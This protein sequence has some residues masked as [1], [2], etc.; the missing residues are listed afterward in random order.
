MPKKR[1]NEEKENSGSF[2][3]FMIVLIFI[4]IWLSVFALLIKFDAG[5]LGTTLRPYLKDI[6]VLRMILP[7]VSE[8][9]EQQEHDYPYK[10]LN[11]AIAV[12]KEYQEQLAALTKENE[13]LKSQVAELTAENN[14]LK[15]YEDNLK[16]FEE[17]VK[18]F[19]EY[20]VFND[21]APDVENYR[22]FYEETYPENAARIYQEVLMLMQFDEELK[23][24]AKL[25]TLM[26]PG[27][28]AK[29]M[30][31][32]TADIGYLTDLIHCMKPAEAA[33]IMD[34]MNDLYVAKI[35]QRMA[36]LNT[37]TRQTLYEILNVKYPE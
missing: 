29:A 8:E 33:A 27:N 36:D 18:K 28:A 37:A 3:A 21:K 30:E 32:M 11:E 4:L 14:R 15:V 26:D 16:A 31:D 20:V 23:S 1:D 6:P 35:L 10:N 7:K 17:R 5:N 22:Q 13:E 12:I 25:L 9:Q 2:V 19:E 34:E 24:Q